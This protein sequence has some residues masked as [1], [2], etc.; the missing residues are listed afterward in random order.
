LVLGGG[1]IWLVYFSHCRGYDDEV[2]RDRR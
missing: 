1:L 2:G